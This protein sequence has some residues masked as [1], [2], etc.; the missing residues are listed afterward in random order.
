MLAGVSPSAISAGSIVGREWAGVVSPGKL[1]EA[2]FEQIGS[3][4]PLSQP[5]P[6]GVAVGFG[7]FATHT[8]YISR[9]YPD[10]NQFYTYQKICLEG[11]NFFT[12]GIPALAGTN[13]AT[14]NEKL[15]ELDWNAPLTNIPIGWNDAKLELKRDSVDFAQLEKYSTT[16]NFVG[17]GYNYLRAILNQQGR[18]AVVP[19]LIE[20]LAEWCSPYASN[21]VYE[22]IFVGKI[23]LNKA[24][25]NYPQRTVSATV[26]DTGP[27]SILANGK[28]MD[29]DVCGERSGSD[30]VP[31][32]LW[33]GHGGA[34]GVTFG[35]FLM[36]GT[37]LHDT[38]GSYPGNKTNQTYRIGAVLGGIVK[39]ISDGQ[40]DFRSDFFDSTYEWLMFS[41]GDFVQ[42]HGVANNQ[43]LPIKFSEIFNELDKVFNL[44]IAFEV[45]GNIPL[46]RIEPKI[47][48]SNTVGAPISLSGIRELINSAPT[49]INYRVLD[50]GY[51][52][53][54]DFVLQ[55]NNDLGDELHYSSNNIADGVH[56]NLVSKFIT[57]TDYLHYIIEQAVTL[58]SADVDDR[59]I[60]F[61]CFYDGVDP[62]FPIKSTQVT[63]AEFNHTIHPI[64]NFNRWKHSLPVEIF[65][66]TSNSLRDYGDEFRSRLV[67]FQ[68]PITMADF[69]KLINPEQKIQISGAGIGGF[70]E[71]IVMSCSRS[72]KT[73]IAEFEVLTQ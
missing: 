29:V 72:M 45:N 69:N 68:S 58:D 4:N 16:L 26:E 9:W 18:N 5:I 36:W 31:A 24:N 52:T 35:N 46:I 13:R 30:P 61:E 12:L 8:G 32:N 17:D 60:L 20:K 14:Q 39:S 53:K 40:V 27:S 41:R 50:I 28:D 34:S 55:T 7:E 54:W 67:K 10:Q 43:V 19:I 25:F 59:L 23:Y 63:V 47:H 37:Q 65:G 70:I 66:G 73:G 57:G 56:L 21:L 22:Q 62:F 44:A 42:G 1:Y 38:I 15:Y 71:G 51:D 2:S 11:N 49:E 6:F 3:S 64:D 33:L 48:F